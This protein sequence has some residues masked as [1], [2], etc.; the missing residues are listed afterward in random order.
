MYMYILF[1]LFGR[2]PKNLKLGQDTC[3]VHV[4]GW[5]QIVWQGLYINMQEIMYFFFY[6]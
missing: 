2:Q 1:E 5:S 3:T 6:F 4:Y